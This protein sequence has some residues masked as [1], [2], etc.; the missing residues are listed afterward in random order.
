MTEEE[1]NALP[2]EQR[3]ALMKQ[4]QQVQAM[5]IGYGAME[6]PYSQSPQRQTRQAPQR[7]RRQE[8][9]MPQYQQ[10]G[11]GGGFNPSQFMSKGAAAVPASGAGSALTAAEASSFTPIMAPASLATGEAAVPMMGEAVAGN[12]GGSAAGTASSGAASGAA[13]GGSAI[14]SAGPAALAA[15]IIANETWANKEGRRPEDFGDHAKDML[16]GK[17]LEYDAKALGKKMP[18]PLAKLTEFHA[19]MGNPKGIAKNVGKALKPWE[20][21]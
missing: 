11:G 4:M 18:K 10:Q 9:A 16:S 12:I 2:P 21:F 14:A 3:A 5:R 15:L 13:S 19:E 1:L 6:D 17:V 7:Q 20:W 8:Q